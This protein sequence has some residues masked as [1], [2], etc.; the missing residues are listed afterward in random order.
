AHSNA[1]F[2]GL[3]WKKK[4]VIYDTLI[5]KSSVPEIEAV[6]AH[7]LD[8]RILAT[9]T[10]FAVCGL[11]AYSRLSPRIRSLLPRDARKAALGTLHLVSLQV[12]LGIS[13]LWY[14]VPTPLAA[15]HQA[16]A[17]ALLTGVFVLGSRVWVPGRTWRLVQR[18]VK[19]ASLKGRVQ[20]STTAAAG[21]KL[22][23]SAASAP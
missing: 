2:T 12:A 16:G 14:L 8:H 21:R 23:G 18:A 11:F 22:G 15:A 5:A 6:L 19:E 10:F 17:L 7:E 3:P 9:T 4:I 1:Y 20:S 13:T